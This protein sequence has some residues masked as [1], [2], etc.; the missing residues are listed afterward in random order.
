MECRFCFEANSTPSNLLISPCACTGTSKYV[1]TNCL[2]RWQRTTTIKTHQMTC[3]QCK[4]DYKLPRFEIIPTLRIWNPSLLIM[5]LHGLTLFSSLYSESSWLSW[6]SISDLVFYIS[7]IFYIMIYITL[8]LQ[9]NRKYH[10][11]VYCI[12]DVRIEP[13]R[14]LINVCM[15]GCVLY[16]YPLFPYFMSI[17]YCYLC[18][19]LLQTH[20]NVL[21][22]M[23][24]DLIRI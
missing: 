16:M 3:Q 15:I 5:S 21:Y 4:T 14:P 23:N 1:H 20:R 22:Q 9:I 12:T 17:L 6:T 11:I 2:L 10:Y 18:A 19:N 7:S 8:F 24:G 13:I